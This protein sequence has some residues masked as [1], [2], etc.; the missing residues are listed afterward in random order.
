MSD[1]STL[2]EPLPKGPISEIIVQRI[3]DALIGGELKPGDKIPTE[4]E[5]S[6]HLSVGRNA[7]RE[8]IKV[9]VA[10]GVL[11]V[12]RSEGTFV[13]DRFHHNLLNPLLYSLPIT[14]KSIDD[15]LEFKVG[16]HY[17]MFYLAML[18]ATDDEITQLRQYCDR[19]YEA[20]LRDPVDVQELFET[21][22]R[23]NLFLGEVT[24]NPMFIRLNE[25]ALR[26]AKYARIKT[27]EVTISQGHPTF[28]AET[29]YK[30]LPILEGRRMEDVP[31]LMK[32]RLCL[33]RDMMED[34]GGS[35]AGSAT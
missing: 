30:D 8:A 11:E 31:A 23:Y 29:Y 20:S 3:A 19:F 2:F 35:G 5:F 26:V 13:V 25:I 33:W 12:R 34:V 16:I 4:Q 21:S 22:E 17:T 24:H 18:H 1:Y 7:V 27:I 9:L 28:W 14:E 6:D 32:R 15:I 10:F